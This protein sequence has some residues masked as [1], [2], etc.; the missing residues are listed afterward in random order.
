MKTATH[1]SMRAMES[2]LRRW[3][4]EPVV[5]SELKVDDYVLCL[6]GGLRRIVARR[7]MASEEGPFLTSAIYILAF[8]D[9]TIETHQIPSSI[10]NMAIRATPKTDE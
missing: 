1:I 6:P 2:M 9:G 8:D 5:H 7:T 3:D 10:H 4:L